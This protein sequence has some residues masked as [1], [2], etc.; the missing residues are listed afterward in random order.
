MNETNLIKLKSILQDLIH[1]EIKSESKD[2]S[3]AFYI[4]LIE[5]VFSQE[6]LLYK[7]IL[8]DAKTLIKDV[9]NETSRLNDSTA[10]G[11]LLAMRLLRSNNQKVKKKI[12]AY[13]NVRLSDFE[14]SPLKNA[15]MLFLLCQGIDYIEPSIKD[16]ISNKLT[17][18][19]DTSHTFENAC[20][21][22]ASYLVL[23]KNAKRSVKEKSVEKVIQ[24]K[25]KE[26]TLSQGV[27]ALW[28]YEILIAPYINSFEQALK[29]RIERWN[30][31]L[32]KQ[33]IPQ[34]LKEL[35]SKPIETGM[36]E[37]LINEPLSVSTFELSL[38]YETILKN[39]DKFLI[40]SQQN[41]T[42]SL[43]EKSNKIYL[44]KIKWQS[45]FWILLSISFF[46]LPWYLLSRF[47]Q[48]ILI[49]AMIGILLAIF[50]FFLRYKHIKYLLIERREWIT[51][52]YKS[53]LSSLLFGI[54][55]AYI[56]SLADVKKLF[57]PGLTETLNTFM[58]VFL[59]AVGILLP[60]LVSPLKNILNDLL[61][62]IK[63]PDEL[64]ESGDYET[65]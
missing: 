32:K 6:S 4:G 39:E 15:M 19:M 12:N 8:D 30:K 9:E 44:G 35:S 53:L 27:H 46:T 14:Y 1:K 37:D 49:I 11:A 17:D 5:S 48:R 16:V 56:T 25:P 52:N 55:V 61:F 20:L 40:I 36:D 42:N 10:I 34:L 50:T 13:L 31:E 23:N 65:K 2:K 21:I 24:Y 59:G 45:Y 7:V 3:I 62:S 60:H 47:N 29:P 18:L 26:M 64:K 22:Y 38:I 51:G 43:I 58:I 33:I 28:F 41:F 63:V 57:L 54:L